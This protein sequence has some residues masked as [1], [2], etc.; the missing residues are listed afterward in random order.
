[1]LGRSD[2]SPQSYTVFTWDDWQ[3]GQA[4]GPYLPP[5]NHIVSIR[6]KRWKIAR[7]FDEAGEVPDQWEFYDLKKDPLEKKNLAWKGVKRTAEQEREFD[8]MKRKL[9]KVE[10]TRLKSLS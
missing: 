3:A 4:R 10:K 1:V 6:E 2:A 9:A 7:Y 8:R 5:P